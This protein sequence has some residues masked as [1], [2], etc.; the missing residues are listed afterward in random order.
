MQWNP[1]ARLLIAVTLHV[2]V[3]GGY[4]RYEM[5]P[6]IAPWIAFGA[7]AIVGF[8]LFSLYIDSI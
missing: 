1:T 4:L 6:D 8:I 2:A 7:G 5:F 3:V